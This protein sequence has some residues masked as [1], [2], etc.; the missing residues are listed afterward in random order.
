MQISFEMDFTE[1]H[2][3][4]AELIRAQKA[5]AKAA[6]ACGLSTAGCNAAKRH[7]QDNIAIRVALTAVSA[8]LAAEKETIVA[9]IRQDTER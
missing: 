8:A 6:E 3:L 1:A 9:K 2:R 7:Q 5:H 4:R